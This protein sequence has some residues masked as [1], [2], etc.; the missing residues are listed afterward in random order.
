MSTLQAKNWLIL[1]QIDDR[2]AAQFPE[3]DRVVLQLLYNR[4]LKEKKE[5]ESFLHPDYAR[6]SFNPFLFKN[7]QVAVALIIAHIKAGDKIIIYGDYDADG[8][9]AS[10]VLAETLAVLKAQVDIYIPDRTSEGYALNKKAID[11]F[12][13]S[14][15]KLII[16]VDCGIR[17][18]DEIIYAKNLGIDVIVTDH[19]QPPEEKS[20][21]PDCLIIN[22]MIKE[23]AY[24]FKYLAGVGVAFKLAKAIISAA[25]IDDES[26]KKLEE[27]I[28]DL[29]AIGTVA[30]CVSLL[31]ENRVLVKEGLK[32]INKKKRLGLV[33]LIKAAQV[34]Y[35]IDSWN[36]GWQIAP[37]LNAAGRLDH[38]NTAYELLTTKDASEAQAIAGR[39]NGKN[40]ERQEITEE[41][42]D[43]CCELVEREM[44][45][46]KILVIAD[47]RILP[48]FSSGSAALAANSNE[49]K[50]SQP[51][52]KAGRNEQFWPDGVVGLVAGRLCERYSRPVLVITE[53]NG[54]IKGSGRSIVECNIVQVIKETEE[55]FQK[56]GGH[57]GACGFTL[58]GKD[59][60]K[61]LREKLKQIGERI[62]AGIELKPKV[63]AEAELDLSAINEDLVGKLEQFAPFGQ[64]NERPRF[65]SRNVQIR[66]IMTM[67]LDGRHI[68]FRLNNFWAVAFNSAEK[69]QDLRIGNTV[70][71]VYYIEMN[72]WSGRSEIQLKVVDIKSRNS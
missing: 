9:T 54:E 55:F 35:D 31:G 20:E 46:D 22:P 23:Y 7:M 67:G 5:M 44:M 50:A 71:A 25:K 68:K 62:L 58:K 43:F 17:N 15:V 18:K 14:G 4:G 37:R 45:N 60:I 63:V 29:V 69:W 41:I 64:N 16:T 33:E 39:L 34:N 70:D 47:P 56:F 61:P 72:E 53:A 26:K 1:P 6:D 51:G 28:L 27:N 19:H 12:S 52:L 3:Y 24:P 30:D 66:D 57:A 8:I 13:Q 36:I 65:V 38:A 2:F 48:S 49:A 40:C 21:W 42:V 10:A 32:I 11:Y 59:S